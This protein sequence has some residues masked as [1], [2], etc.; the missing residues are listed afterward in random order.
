MYTEL[1]LDIFDFRKESFKSKKTLNKRATFVCS[2]LN[3][4]LW[5][6]PQ[7][8]GIQDIDITI[9]RKFLEYYKTKDNGTQ[10]KSDT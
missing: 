7:I 2:F 3:Y 6:E 1:E 4:L 5:H 10:W 9:V 8:D